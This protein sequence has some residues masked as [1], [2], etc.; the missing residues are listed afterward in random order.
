MDR[1]KPSTGSWSP[2]QGNWQPGGHLAGEQLP[3]LTGG[4]KWK[5]STSAIK[6]N[7][8]L[9]FSATRMDPESIRLSEVSQAEKDKYHMTSLICEI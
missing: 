8:V 6:K 4:V 9:P 2:A 5:R 3:C 7:E 1:A